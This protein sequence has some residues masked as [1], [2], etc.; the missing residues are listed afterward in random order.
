MLQHADNQMLNDD[1]LGIEGA[2]ERSF[3]ES[4]MPTLQYRERSTAVLHATQIKA[5]R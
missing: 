5:E 4:N 1:T 2:V 3:A